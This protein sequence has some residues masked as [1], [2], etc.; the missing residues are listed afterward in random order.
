MLLEQLKGVVAVKFRGEG[1][2]CQIRSLVNVV[3]F[4]LQVFPNMIGDKEMVDRLE[5]RFGIGDSWK[6]GC[7]M[8][9][10]ELLRGHKE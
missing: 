4:A 6:G 5:I 9:I 7:V 3:A 2:I 10:F 1:R 8:M